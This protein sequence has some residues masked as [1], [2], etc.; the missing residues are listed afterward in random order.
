MET[1][2]FIHFPSADCDLL[3]IY[4]AYSSG[5]ASLT[6]FSNSALKTSNAETFPLTTCAVSAQ[7]FT[8]SRGR[9]GRRQNTTRVV[10]HIKQLADFTSRESLWIVPSINVPIK[11]G[12]SKII[13]GDEN[14]GVL[15]QYAAVLHSSRF[16]GCIGWNWH[17]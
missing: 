12:Q 5:I 2:N 4:C 17:T 10:E 15:Q 6:P 8:R 16:S 9:R 11:D 13:S 7:L 1:L 14:A 3:A